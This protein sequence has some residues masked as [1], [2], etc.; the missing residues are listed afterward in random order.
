MLRWGQ[1][2]LRCRRACCPRRAR[3]RPFL[4]TPADA[5]LLLLKE[6][7]EPLVTPLVLLPLVLLLLLVQLVLLLLLGLLAQS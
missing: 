1:Q 2:R 4:P 3:H 5:P 6:C 7:V